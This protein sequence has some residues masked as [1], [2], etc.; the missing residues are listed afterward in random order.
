MIKANQL[1]IGDWVLLNGI[2]PYRVA[3]LNGNGTVRLESEDSLLVLE[4]TLEPVPLTIDFFTR[5][6]LADSIADVAWSVMPEACGYWRDESG[7]DI[8][9]VFQREEGDTSYALSLSNLDEDMSLIL[10]SCSHVHEFQHALRL[11]GIEREVT[12]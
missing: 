1:M 3:G 4:D 10:V 6:G 9:R 11:S 7:D 2:T 5:N 12:L 8:I